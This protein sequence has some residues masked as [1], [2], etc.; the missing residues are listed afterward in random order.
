MDASFPASV[1]RSSPRALAWA[2]YHES[3]VKLQFLRLAP[4]PGASSGTERMIVL[5]ETR[6][7]DRAARAALQARVQEVA[8]DIAGMLADDI[9]LAPPRTVPKTSSG[10]IR[11]SAAKELYESG[12]VG[13]PQRALWRQVLRL[14]LTGIG[15]QLVRLI[16][17]LRETLY[18]IRWWTQPAGRPAG[19]F[20]GGGASVR[21]RRGVGNG[22][23]PL[24]RPQPP[25]IGLASGARTLPA[26]GCFRR[27]WGTARSRHQ[28]YACGASR[29]AHPILHSGGYRLLP[30]R[31]HFHRCFA[32]SRPG[33]HLSIR[34]DHLSW[35]RRVHACRRSGSH[36]H[37]R[38]RRRH[39]RS[40][41]E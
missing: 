22:A 37:Q 30:A 40:S 33:S 15:P 1:D 31:R 13:A 19:R 10:K 27:L 3:R 7:T 5:A 29:L 36:L 8:M 18:A 17:V 35:D 34:R 11:R 4:E 9:V 24:L 32:P 25:W 16:A 38:G 12:R 20:V 2:R 6:Q 23:R 14:S 39:A 21:C 28:Y 26:A 41:G